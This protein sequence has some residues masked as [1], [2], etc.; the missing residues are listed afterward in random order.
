MLPRPL[1]AFVLSFL[2]YRCELWT[3]LT[4]CLRRIQASKNTCL[5]SLLQLSYVECKAIDFVWQP[6]LWDTRNPFSIKW[7]GT[8][9]S[10]LVMWPLRL[11]LEYL[12]DRCWGGQRKNQLAN[13]KKWLVISCRTCSLLPRISLSGKP[14]QSLHMSICTLPFLPMTSITICQLVPHKGWMNEYQE[15]LWYWEFKAVHVYPKLE[16]CY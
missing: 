3:L 11:F 5:M 7:S 4:S 1:K 6:P 8:S 13:V 15:H 12:G 2:L 14:C 16:A 9:W 10:G